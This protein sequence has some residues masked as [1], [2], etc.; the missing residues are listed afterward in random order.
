[1]GWF[2][3]F[4]GQYMAAKSLRQRHPPFTTPRHKGNC[5]QQLSQHSP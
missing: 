4:D 2:F 5:F 3:C 1:M